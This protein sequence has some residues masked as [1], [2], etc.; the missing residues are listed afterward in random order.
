[1][2]MRESHLERRAM[3]MRLEEIMLRPPALRL[4]KLRS[5][6]H[7]ILLLTSLASPKKIGLV[8]GNLLVQ[9]FVKKVETH[10]KH[11]KTRQGRINQER[12]CRLGEQPTLRGLDSMMDLGH[13]WMK[14]LSSIAETH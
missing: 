12:P 8:F 7:I 2:E 4:T 14:I 1:M 11:G 6:D 10:G 3:F 9:A 13:H 5:L